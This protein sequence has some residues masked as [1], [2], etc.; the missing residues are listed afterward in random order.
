MT[1]LVFSRFSPR[2]ARKFGKATSCHFRQMPNAHWKKDVS[3]FSVSFCPSIMS[4]NNG[5]GK[6][7]T[8]GNHHV[9][10]FAKNQVLCGRNNNNNNR[11]CQSIHTVARRD[12]THILR[13]HTS[14]H[15]DRVADPGD[16]VCC[17]QGNNTTII[18]Q[19]DNIVTKVRETNKYVYVS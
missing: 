5:K 17:I 7:A 12:Y 11:C 10:R 2:K 4:V 18:K 1:F 8:Y 16:F 19:R 9:L 3:V 15:S 13:R 14:S 6:H